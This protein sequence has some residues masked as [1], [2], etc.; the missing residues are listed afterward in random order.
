MERKILRT[1]LLNFGYSS[2]MVRKLIQGTTKPTAD[3]MFKLE[4]MFNIPVS[5]WR[6]IKSYLQEN[7]TKEQCTSATTT[8]KEGVA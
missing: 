1:K 8:Q 4:D 3:K 7:D 5:A 2:V 6:D